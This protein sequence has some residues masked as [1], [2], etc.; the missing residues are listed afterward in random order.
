MRHRGLSAFPHVARPTRASL[1][2]PARGRRLVPLVTT[3]AGQ[4]GGPA[5]APLGTTGGARRGPACWASNG[6]GPPIRRPSRTCSFR[7]LASE[8]TEF[9]HWLARFPPRFLA[10]VR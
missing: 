10:T 7:L 2:G 5:R 3:G 1:V 8:P 9:L 4:R 6:G